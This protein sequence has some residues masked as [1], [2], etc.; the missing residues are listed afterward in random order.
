MLD[1]LMRT[2]ALAGRVNRTY[3]AIPKST[4]SIV[5]ARVFEG[6]GIGLFTYDQRNVE[7]ALPARYFEVNEHAHSGAADPVP[8]QLESELRELRIQF[9]S[10]ENVVR[11]MK[12]ELAS[13]RE[14]RTPERSVQTVAQPNPAQGISLASSLPGFF[15]GNPWVEVLSRRGREENTI[16]G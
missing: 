10:L 1:S 11:Q 5:D 8:T 12:E 4:A 6:I 2:S 9:D 16:A 14:T 3:L 7:E 13:V 15:M